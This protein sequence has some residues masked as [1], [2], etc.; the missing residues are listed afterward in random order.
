MQEISEDLIEKIVSAAGRIMEL[1]TGGPNH[2][3]QEARE[4]IPDYRRIA[5][6]LSQPR[7]LPFSGFQCDRR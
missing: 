2:K 6:V 4:Q 3:L 7:R 5:S 1:L